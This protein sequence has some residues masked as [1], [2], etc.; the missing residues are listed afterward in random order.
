MENEDVQSLKEQIQEMGNKLIKAQ[1]DFNKEIDKVKEEE[2][3]NVKKENADEIFQLQ[4]ALNVVK[5]NNGNL[6]KDKKTLINKIKVITEKIEDKVSEGIKEKQKLLEFAPN[7][8][9]A[10]SLLDESIGSSSAKL[11]SVYEILGSNVD[12][13][14][15]QRLYASLMNIKDLVEIVKKLLGFNEDIVFEN[16]SENTQD[17][18]DIKTKEISMD[19]EENSN[20]E[21]PIN[22]NF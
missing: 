7:I 19:I 5:A 6:I 4:H 16:K 2:R 12:D 15:K 10:C 18:F 1:E 21:I 11:N 22:L 14:S 17:A 9:E 8:I 20:N 13:N 3:K